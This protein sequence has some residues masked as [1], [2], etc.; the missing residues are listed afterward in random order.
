MVE[1]NEQRKQKSALQ[2]IERK[3][4]NGLTKTV[5]VLET[6]NPATGAALSWTKRAD[7]QIE[8]PISVLADVIKTL[9]D[10]DTRGTI[11]RLLRAYCNGLEYDIQVKQEGI[12]VAHKVNKDVGASR[13]KD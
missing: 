12:K 9:G 5:V 7:N 8:L 1:T 6:F 13:S 4:K 3:V 11:N 10:P 2:I